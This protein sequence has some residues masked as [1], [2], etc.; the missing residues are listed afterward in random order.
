[1]IRG[2]SLCVFLVWFVGV[3]VSRAAV[4]E[5]MSYQGVLTDGGGN[6]VADGPYDLTFKLYD[7]PTDGTLL[8]SEI[9]AAVAVTGGGF[10]VLL[11]SVAPLAL[12]F[13]APYYL[14]ISVGADPELAPRVPLASSPYGLGLRLPF[15]G[16][17]ASAGP[18]LA[19]DNAGGGPA[20]VLSGPSGDGAVVL[21]TD[22]ISAGEILDEPGVA[23]TT[24][25]S[26]TNIG[27]SVAALL[28][29]TITVP[30][31][32]YV[33]ALATCDM[34]LY[35]TL[36]TTENL[37][38]GLSTSASTIPANHDVVYSLGGALPTT[39]YTFPLSIQAL[40]PV[41]A[42]NQT[43]YLLGRSTGAGAIVGDKQLSL[44]FFP[45]ACGTVNLSGPSG[46][47]EGTGPGG[48]LTGA[49]LAAE[50]SESGQFNEERVRREV[51]AM[52]S[53][54]ASL[55]ARLVPGT[56]SVPSDTATRGGVR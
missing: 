36:N 37:I 13:D 4:P 26:A 16:S 43:F 21:P 55:E 41:S 23:G 51:A 24:S 1:M 20:M 38:V 3:S 7:A 34:T 19:I 56:K 12:P 25:E 54:L 8:W 18:A 31:D 42:G 40:F 6:P 39:L 33:L 28:S 44:A 2:F 11:G 27:S 49:D 48:A 47:Q 45:T 50:R 14:G 53:Q 46:S 22:A 29:R 15:A 32:G 35:H 30:T 9:Q 10:S 17:V 5:T 52:R